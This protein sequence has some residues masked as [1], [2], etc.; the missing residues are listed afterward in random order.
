MTCVWLRSNW[1]RHTARRPALYV[2]CL[3]G[4]CGCGW[5]VSSRVCSGAS[6]Y[7]INPCSNKQN[8][9][10][11]TPEV[12]RRRANE[13]ER[14]RSRRRRRLMMKASAT[15]ATMP[16]K[17]KQGVSMSQSN[18]CHARIHSYTGAHS[19]GV[20]QSTPLP[21]N[22][23]RIDL[24]SEC[25]RWP[26]PYIHIKHPSPSSQQQQSSQWRTWAT[27]ARCARSTTSCPC[28]AFGDTRIGCPVCWWIDGGVSIKQKR[29]SQP[30]HH[31]HRP[32]HPPNQP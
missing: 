30:A 31:T 4:W 27:S 12:P 3:L 13:H 9:I 6:M 7:S 23:S 21:L 18:R 11:K 1:K 24:T 16:K 20:R 32:S 26:P 2:V 28:G 8:K 29:A 10:K 19:H 22:H 25:V 17:S 15:I 5:C 14:E